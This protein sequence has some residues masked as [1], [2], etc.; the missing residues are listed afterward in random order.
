MDMKQ[1]TLKRALTLDRAHRYCV[2]SDFFNI[3]VNS[4]FVP[5]A[6]NLYCFF[7][8]QPHLLLPGLYQIWVKLGG[9][10]FTERH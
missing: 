1:F 7:E 9:L 10:A 2:N 4:K 8:E 5:S 6:T 3:G